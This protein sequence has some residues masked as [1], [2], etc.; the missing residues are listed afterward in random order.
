MLHTLFWL[1]ER[2]TWQMLKDSII[3]LSKDF[4]NTSRY[5]LVIWTNKI[6]KIL[7]HIIILAAFSFLFGELILTYILNQVSNSQIFNLGVAVF[8]PLA[9]TITFSGLMYNRAKAINS[10]TQR[11]RSIYIAERLFEAS[12]YYILCL[13]S[14]FICYLII[15]KFQLQLKLDGTI[16]ESKASLIILPSMSFF[17]SFCIEIIFLIKAL[18][19]QIGGRTPNR[20]ALKVR[21][22]L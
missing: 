9:I 6:A 21:K 14:G 12:K 13:L 17:M 19:F 22:L 4:I 8:S 11:F 16:V 7:G 18:G 3:K 1:N 10:K 2:I 15:S 5:H 20:V